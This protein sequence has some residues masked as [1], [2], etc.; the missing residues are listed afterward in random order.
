MKKTKKVYIGMTADILHHGHMNILEKARK[1][2]DIIVGL[3]TDSAIAEYKRLPYLNYKQREKILKN[4]QG[5]TKVIPQKEWDYSYNI[6]KLRPD[7][8]VHGDDWKTGADKVLRKNVIKALN[9]DGGKLIE[10][11]YTKGVSSGAF[12]NSQRIISTTP[13]IR[14]STLIR[15]IDSK[16]ILRIIETH[17]P[18]S[19]IIAEKSF[20]QKGGKKISFDGFWSSSLTDS[21]VMGKPD[22]ES[23]E[24]SKRLSHI[25]D[26][27][28]VTTKPLILDA[29]TGGKIEHFEMKIKSMDRLGIS[30]VI[31]E[32]KTGLK[33]NSLH[34][35]TSQQV[36][37]DKNKFA[38]KISVG[39]KAKI[40]EDFMIIARIESLI[41][42]K[43]MKD[44]IERARKYVEAGVDG[45][46]IH[47]KSER[48]NEIFEFAK[49]FR[50]DF[51]DMPLVSVPTSYNKVSENELSENGFNIVI[52]AN[53]M[54]RAAYPAMQTVANKILKYGRSK[55][56][57]KELISINKILELIP[58]TK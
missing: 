1:Y 51:K 53:Q 42:K 35:D 16:N 13:E 54:L 52:Y 28:E 33:K 18:L 8:V 20:L 24:I 26:I 58:G 48:P 40:S 44:A 41:L 22:T 34:K 29:D 57:D 27:F 12:V 38:E 3:L 23:L 31:I 6:R 25:N 32:D 10:V 19:A 50:K 21:T 43:G 11:P 39:K 5:V 7:F 15:L 2:G 4:L 56:V 49:K 9:E 14:R 37:E 47:S 30:A 17:S 55:E 45:I 36:Q 46:M